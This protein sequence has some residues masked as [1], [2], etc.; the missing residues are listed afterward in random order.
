MTQK[1][2]RERGNFYEFNVILYL[3]WPDI[4]FKWKIIELFVFLKCT[5]CFHFMASYVSVCVVAVVGACIL[6]LL[7][8][9]VLFLLMVYVSVFCCCGGCVLMLLVMVFVLLVV[10]MCFIISEGGMCAFLLLVVVYVICV[11]GGDVCVCM[12]Y[13]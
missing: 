3:N 4:F 2:H 9:G 8:V 11:I 7:V 10:C 13:Y 12:F 6:L 1:I 5:V